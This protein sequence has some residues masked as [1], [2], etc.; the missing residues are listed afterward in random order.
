MLTLIRSNRV[1]CLLAELARRLVS[2]PP[3]SVFT[4]ATVV[5]PSPAMARWVNLRLAAA[6][7]VAANIDYPLPA[8]FVWALA[9]RLLGDLPEADPLSVEAMTWRGF[10][11]LP[12]LL[13]RAE[14]ADLERYLQGD[15]DGR[16]RWQLAARIADAF[17]R[18]QLYRP[19]LIRA[20]TAGA[21]TG[22]TE[23]PWQPLLWQRLVA[24]RELAHRG[25]VL[26]RLL[27]A[28]ETPGVAAAL[29][30]RL[31]LFAV[32]SLP[33]VLVQV[34]QALAAYMPVD[35][36]LHAPTDQFWTDLVSQKDL[37]RR[38]LARPD[39]ADL[40]EVSNPLLGSWGRQGQAM[41]DL[42]LQGETPIADCDAY[43]TDWPDTLLGRLQQDLFALTPV[44][45]PV[46]RAPL[47]PDDSVQ[48][49]LCHGPAR[50]CQ[51]LHDALLALFEAEPDLRPED[52]LVM[53]PDIARYAADIAAVFDRHRLDPAAAGT[54]V[55]TTGTDAAARFIPWNLSD[56]A[57]ADEHP[58]VLVF[59]KLLALPESRFTQS[60]VLSYLDVPE[61][62]AH[63]GLEADA[64]GQLRGWLAATNLRWGLNGLHKASLGLPAMDQNTWAQAGARLF[65]GYA[66]GEAGDGAPGADSGFAGIAP[67]AGVEGSAAAALGVFWG[68]FDRLQQAARRLAAPRPAADWERDLGR[69]LADLFGERD[70]PDGRL[71][72]IRDALAGLAEQAGDISE[73]LSLP[74]VRQWLTAR[75]G[76]VAERRGGRWFSGGVTFCG[77]RP[78]RSLP[79]PVICVLGLDDESFPRRDRPV[80]LDPMRRG[81]RPGDPRKGDEDRY[82]FLETLLGARR[83]LY[84]S[85]VGRDAHNN[86]ERQ[87]S[88]L[89]RELLD[90]ID[91]YFVT[92]DGGRLSAAIT[93]VH[94]LQPFSPAR[95]APAQPSFDADWCRIARRMLARA[96]G[97]TPPAPLAWP[98]AVIPDAPEAMRE[99]SLKQLERFLAHPVRWFVQTR[100]GVHLSET[101]PEPDEEPFALDGLDAWQLKTRLLEDHLAG[102]PATAARLAAEGLLPHGAFGGLAL[103]RQERDLA[104][105]AGALA[106]YVGQC[107]ARLDLDLAVDGG[108]AGALRLSGQVDG[109]YPGLGLLRWRAGRLRGEDR[110]RLWLAHLA[111]WAVA[112][113]SLA[114]APEPSCLYT[115]EDSFQLRRA[116]SR[117][118]AR[119]RLGAL[120]ALY[121]AG[122]HRPL[123][124]FRE[125]SY[126]FAARW[127]ADDPDARDRARADA[128]KA[129]TG[130]DFS[131]AGG[132]GDDPYVQL[133]LR[134][135]AGGDPL[136][137]PDFERLA[138]DLYGPLLAAAEE[139]DA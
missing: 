120:A 52:V 92:P 48:V 65:A 139:D 70:D 33:P 118:A 121:W 61:L 30:E 22:A 26:D 53:V 123:P 37:A 105:L 45:G 96:P 24:G 38:R 108:E 110:L 112:D 119:A 133:V 21:P 86:T 25:A 15:T 91:Q 88:V 115:Q 106:P 85:Y 36:Y 31:S 67:V 97:P 128:R 47:L 11:L 138:L 3:A 60:E 7:G 54:D 107:P 100:L 17:D 41:Q 74:L 102:R 124:I 135:G 81:W 19:E 111:R 78:L 134:E 29:P 69:L 28:L 66:L 12:A 75:L 27:A 136:A 103:E 127:Q 13:P 59:L 40:W 84:L 122:L 116:P 126:A 90:H 46:A 131:R 62:A 39:D 20:W 42:L 50:E 82:L 137:D 101:D 125:A 5:T 43:A 44:P 16:K 80:E 95:F 89:L 104:P 68:L 64:V 63:F 35:L 132:D 130:S 76:D 72:R 93:R 117:D 79:F 1:E 83:R 34:F 55:A 51:V 23:H 18:C 8:S 129:W 6:C 14:L 2:S 99:I 49:H 10:A 4:A 56:I 87:P 58:L 77:M 57:V 9:Q 73:P 94:P 109:I 32:S 71:Q 114:A 113:A 98:R